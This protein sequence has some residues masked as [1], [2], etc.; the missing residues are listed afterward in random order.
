MGRGMGNRER[1]IGSWK[2]DGWMS[3]WKDRWIDEMDG[4]IDL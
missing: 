4:W 3:G 2:M 1:W